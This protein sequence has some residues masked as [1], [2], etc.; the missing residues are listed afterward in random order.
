MDVQCS[1]GQFIITSASNRLLEIV[2]M[3]QCDHIPVSVVIPCFRCAPTIKRAIDSIVQQSAIPTE[4]ILV[5][6]ASG[7]ETWTVLTEL[8]QAYP[9]WVKV[10]QL[11]ENRGAASARNAGWNLAS[12]PYIAFLDADDAWHP[13]KIEFQLAYMDANPDVA[14]SGHGHR[15]MSKNSLPDWSISQGDARVISKLSLLFSNKI[16]TPSI[17][18]RR[19]VSYRFL[20]GRRYMEDQLLLLEMVFDGVRID[21]I[22]IDLVATYK[23]SYGAGG[24]SA[25]LWRME[26]YELGNYRYFHRNKKLSLFYFYGLILF[27][28]LKFLRRVCISVFW[29]IRDYH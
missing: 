28:L 23:R 9:G 3:Q 24:L 10:L 5:D 26:L 27:S 12:Q 4:V 14:L 15:L 8:E 29:R 18:V 2:N 6:D 7:D 22:N 20:A 25:N 11:K 17:M 19:N 1:L 21:K 13:R 16:V